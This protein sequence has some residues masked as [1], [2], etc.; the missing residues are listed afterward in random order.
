M[1]IS[2][3]IF[4]SF[5]LI[6]LLFSINTFINFRL[7][8]AVNENAGYLTKS[9]YI[10]RTTGRFQRNILNMVN[11]LRGYLLTNENYFINNYDSA[12]NENKQILKDLAKTLSD[13][14]QT[15]IFL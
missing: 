10:I 15:N 13:S 6:L 3:Y 12:A 9:A 2:T 4:L 8:Q 5:V 11:G 1:K 7:S 14:S